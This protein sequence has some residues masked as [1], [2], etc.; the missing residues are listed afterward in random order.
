MPRKCAPIVDN[1]FIGNKLSRGRIA[2]DRTRNLDLRQI[3]SPIVVF[4]SEGDNITPPEQALNWIADI[5]EDERELKAAGQTIVYLVH[6]N[7]GH[8]GIFVSGAVAKH[9]HSEIVG[10]LDYIERL[11]PGL[12]EMLITDNP[13]VGKSNSE[14]RY[15]VDFAERAVADILSNDGGSE[16]EE[17]FE[18]VKA[19]SKF[20][21]MAY[22]LF[23]S[24]LVRTLTTEASAEFLR[25]AHPL[26][27]SR[28]AVSDRNPLFLGLPFL[29][30]RI[31]A[32]RRPIAADNPFFAMERSWAEWV[33]DMLDTY[34]DFRDT[35]VEVA[36][37]AIYGWL[38]FVGLPGRLAQAQ[39]QTGDD[40]SEHH[41]EVAA[42]LAKVASGDSADAVI[43]MLLLLLHAQGSISRPGLA[44]VY[45]V[46]QPRAPFAELPPEELRHR[47][48]AQTITVAYE[49]EQALA[50]LPSLLKT[51]SEQRS[52]LA[53]V[54]AAAPR[55]PEENA[56]VAAM[57]ARFEELP[58][59]R[60]DRV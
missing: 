5:Y 42:V 36:F 59:R 57:R 32:V 55:D 53:A 39:W 2:L 20:N 15:I 22:D 37:Q 17:E 44:H 26:R 54:F 1:L 6:S 33:T 50:T 16:D 4:C 11:P 13:E 31:R 19:I 56:G 8:L 52:A 47:V 49:P 18:I 14:P 40:D 35:G 25:Q 58:E 48:R 24:P 23:A 41:G 51:E 29:A 30:E 3:R 10:A 46:L 9:E 7:I 45:D 12:Y 27:M 21:G 60:Q 34:R 43:R 38:N 28:Y